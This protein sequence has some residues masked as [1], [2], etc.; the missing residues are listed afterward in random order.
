MRLNAQNILRPTKRLFDLGFRVGNRV[1][2][3]MLFERGRNPVWA[4]G[5]LNRT[6][7]KQNLQPKLVEQEQIV[8]PLRLSRKSHDRCA[9]HLICGVI[10]LKLTGLLTIFQI[11][12]DK[13]KIRIGYYDN[14]EYMQ[15][16]PA[17][18]RAVRVA[19]AALERAGYQVCVKR[20]RA[21]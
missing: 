11:F 4:P 7:S 1:P 20:L 15:A 9:D 13:K 18:K 3:P 12:R 2:L 14:L 10:N 8:D 5:T 17:C 6:A 19:K 16:T 21:P